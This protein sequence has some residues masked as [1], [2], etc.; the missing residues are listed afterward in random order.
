MNGR[1][2]GSPAA[3]GTTRAAIRVVRGLDAAWIEARAAEAAAALA[4][5]R[6]WSWQG[7]ELRYRDFRGAYLSGIDLRD[8]DLTGS[9]FD[10]AV[11]IGA[12]FERAMLHR[13]TFT[14]ADTAGARFGGEPFGCEAEARASRPAILELAEGEAPRLS[15]EFTDAAGRQLGIHESVDWQSA[16]CEFAKSAWIGGLAISREDER[17]RGSRVDPKLFAQEGESHDRQD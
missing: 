6:P 5:W 2:P 9:W 10:G 4:S 3:L 14:G 13:V 7:A 17:L 11:L 12:R 1:S 8:V 16:V 15:V